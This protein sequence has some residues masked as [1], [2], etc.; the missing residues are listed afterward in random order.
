MRNK[1]YKT[2]HNNYSRFFKFIFFL[3]YLVGIFFISSILFLVI[4][5]IFNY[6]NKIEV[7][8]NYLLKT[9][10]FEI[11]NYERV[12]FKAFPLP[13]LIFK[14][15]LIKLNSS[16]VEIKVKNLKIYPKLLNIYN[17]ENYRSNKIILKDSFAQLKFNDSKIFI[18]YLLDQKN[19]FFFENLNINVNDLNNT[20]ISLKNI[21]FSNFGY[22]KNLVSGKVFG[23]NFRIKFDDNI[24]S[25]NFRFH[26]TGIDADID[27]KEKKKNF[28]SGIVKSKILKTNV[29]FKF[30]YDKKSLNINNLFLRNNNL[31]L[32]SEGIIL[33]DPFFAISSKFKIDD[34]NTKIFNNINLDKLLKEKDIFKQF[35]STNNI[36]FKSKKFNRSFIDE[37]NLIINLAYGSLNYNKKILIGKN[38]FQ[39]EGNIN[40]LEEFPILFFNCIINSDNK[41][42]LLAKFNI[43]SKKKNKNFKLNFTGNINVLNKKI[44]FTKILINKNYK[45]TAEDLKYFKNIFE[46]IVFDRNFVEIFN[47]KKI[48]KFILEVS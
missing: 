39:C 24:D 44:N 26:K 43:K 42:D 4:P 7:L 16:S 14:N 6:E 8:N 45:A 48:K 47:I 34:I 5:T 33:L 18:K 40:L 19:K 17:Y 13:K 25:I 10:N 31:S 21:N 37:L 38:L 3:R 35:N 29:K 1:I 20:I 27:L 41:K 46:K 15:I 22:K 11:S 30:D 9:Y 2:I 28:I 12:E 23:R 32:N 36:S